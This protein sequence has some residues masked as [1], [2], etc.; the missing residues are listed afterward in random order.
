MEVRR[1]LLHWS[2]DL[3]LILFVAGRGF[4]DSGEVRFGIS[5]YDT[6]RTAIY[7]LLTVRQAHVVLHALAGIE[8]DESCREF[9]SRAEVAATGDGSRIVLKGENKTY[10]IGSGNSLASAAMVQM[11]L[12]TIKDTCRNQMDAGV[13]FRDGMLTALRAAEEPDPFA[14]I[15]G[16]FDLSGSDSHQWKTNLKLFDA[17][18]CGLVKTPPTT[19]TSA[20]VW[21]L[22]C[23]FLSTSG[24]Y[25]GMVKSVQSVLNLPYQP[26]ETA[27]DI[28]QVFFADP[29][30][31]TW[32]LFVARIDE[33]TVGVSIVAARSGTSPAFPSVVPFPRAASVPPTEPTVR[34]EV[35]KIRLGTHLPMPPAQRSVVGGPT[36]SG[37]TMMTV[38][39]STSYELS[40]FFDGPV[41]TKLT[42]VPGASQDVDLAAGTFHVA[43]RVAAANVLP[44]YGEEAYAGSTRYS[45]T[46]YIAP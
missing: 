25:E 10:V 24:G 20:P 22:A 34:D 7:D 23:E 36:P 30:R 1:R 13:E 37:R 26:D 14:S 45:M 31:P 4:A 17:E 27:V 44:F 12:Q 46:F 5:G 2:I 40:V 33:A 38:K 16:E 3:G 8:V 39:N 21:A 35:E 29:S 9:V 19:P 42:L 28:N 6:N 11:F 18:K 41:S 32:R 15:R 43:G